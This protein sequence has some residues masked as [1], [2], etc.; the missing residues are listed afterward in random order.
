MRFWGFMGGS[1]KRPVKTAIADARKELEQ[2]GDTKVAE[3]P[4]LMKA[5]SAQAARFAYDLS[6]GTQKL[7]RDEIPKKQYA[8]QQ[9]TNRLLQ[10]VAKNTRTPGTDTTA[11]DI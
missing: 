8:E 4:D 1:G 5:G 9:E 2:T 10:E 11:V 7:S 3:A 6:R